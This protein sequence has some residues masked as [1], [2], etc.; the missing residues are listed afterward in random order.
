MLAIGALSSV[1]AANEETFNQDVELVE[2]LI[3]TGEKIE[4]SLQDTVA[5]V[6][7]LTRE[8]LDQSVI[9]D[10]DKIIRR[11]PN[12]S[13]NFGGEGVV[14]RGIPQQGLGNGTFDPVSVT[15]A[16]YIDGVVQNFNGSTNGILSTWDIQ[17]VE[18]FRGPQT[19][20]QGRAG[21]AGAMVIN[22]ANPSFD[23]SARGRVL[24]TTEDRQQYAVAAGGPIIDDVLAF[25]VAAD[26][27]RD[28]GSSDFDFNGE[29]ADNTGVND[30]SLVRGKL[31][32]APSNEFDALVTV[33]YSDGK[34][35][36]NVVSG[37]DFFQRTTN[38]VTNVQETEVTAGSLVMTYQLSDQ[39]NIQ[40][41]T[42]ITVLDTLGRVADGTENGN[43][44][45]VP[46]VGDDR[47]FTQEL[48]LRY[49]S[50]EALS[51][52][53]GLYYADIEE[54]FE[55]TIT[56][57]AGPLTVFRNDGFV[58]DY[59][60]IAVF[61]QVEYDISPSTT[62]TLGG[63]FENEDNRNVQFA[64]TDIEPD[65]PGL[66]DSSIFLESDGSQDA[67]LPKVGITH[68]FTEDISLSFFY[69]QSYRPGGTDIDPRDSSPI[70]FEPEFTD[71]YD[72]A[73][74]SI[75][76]NGQVRFNANAFFVRY[77]DQQQRF[78][79][80]PEIPFIR[81]VN[82]VGKSELYGLEIET[83]YHPVKELSLYGSLGLLETKLLE[84][85][86]ER[87]FFEGEEFPFS[88]NFTFALGGTYDHMSG[89]T[90]SLDLT[91]SSRFYSSSPNSEEFEIGSYLVVDG[92]VGYD[93]GKW[94]AYL[95]VE[96]LTDKNYFQTV[97]RLDSDPMLWTANI[98]RPRTF[99]LIL[100]ASF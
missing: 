6:S 87:N 73:F 69:Q 38:Q 84:S 36:A 27:T 77:N 28:D 61:G 50:G 22:S 55:R 72:L 11:T 90:G 1:A 54:E 99:G 43:G 30:R 14:F 17:Q 35:G 100:E 12:V 41:I 3:V 15:S 57:S 13:S 93:A 96:N 19:A 59:K 5:S 2:E 89:F 33:I 78:A 29:Q 49:D 53:L 40:A 98:S 58:K 51:G 94:G 74:R 25:R 18:V 20:T 64:I 86:E 48:R 7:V 82:N 8:Q 75:L 9:I 66:P 68:R 10:V 37:P 81:F 47:A 91:Y 34:R 79:P 88:P 62:L 26:V 52:L 97:N 56:G 76:A 21:L 32:F 31:L 65:F 39:F 23:W 95:F 83:S 44:L 24:A 60:N 16:M 80:N 4:R 45:A 70:A 42:G 71:N 92:R 46:S 85:N 67:V 63:R